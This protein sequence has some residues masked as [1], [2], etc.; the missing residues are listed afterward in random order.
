MDNV[1]GSTARDHRRICHASRP[2]APR[3][4]LKECVDG[5]LRDIRVR[6]GYALP[7]REGGDLCAPIH[8]S[9]LVV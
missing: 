3:L 1:P 7:H 8:Y 2:H 9:E 6:D 5:V 4:I